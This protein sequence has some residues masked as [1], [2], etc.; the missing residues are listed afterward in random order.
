MTYALSGMMFVSLTAAAMAGPN[1]CPGGAKTCPAGA[2]AKVQ[3]PVKAGKMTKEE[4]M[5][6]CAAKGIKC[7]LEACKSGKCPLAAKKA[8]AKK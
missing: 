5:K 1:G 3:C 6:A 7:N 2:K 4:C 8:P